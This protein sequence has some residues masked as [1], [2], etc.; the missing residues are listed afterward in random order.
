[1]NRTSWVLV[2]L[3]LVSCASVPPCAEEQSTIAD[4]RAI[5]LAAEAYAVD[6]NVYPDAVGFS[7][8]GPILSPNYIVTLPQRD[9]WGRSFEYVRL[10]EGQ[11]YLF[12]SGGPDGESGNSDDIV[13]TDGAFVQYPSCASTMTDNAQT[14]PVWTDTTMTGDP[15]TTDT[16]MTDTTMRD[17]TSTDTIAPGL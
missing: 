14:D 16:T 2:I 1:M 5:A 17:F 6:H 8:L 7:G 13:Y 10:E 15:T 12:R 4:I 11:S 9:A 3:I